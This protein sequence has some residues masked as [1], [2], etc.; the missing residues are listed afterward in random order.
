MS[1]GHLSGP[2]EEASVWKVPQE[3]GTN[4]PEPTVQPCEPDTSE[5]DRP[6]SV[7]TSDGLTP[8]LRVH[9]KQS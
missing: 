2:V 7:K 6:S 5:A 9:P 8:R 3:K 4:V 1:Q